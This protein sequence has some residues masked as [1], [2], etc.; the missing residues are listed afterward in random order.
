MYVVTG[1]YMF[2][3]VWFVEFVS[4]RDEIF[5]VL[6]ET[7][8]PMYLQ[9]QHTRLHCTDLTGYGNLHLKQP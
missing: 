5:T 7:Q 9:F 1:V 4:S 2:T 6:P 3:G 8:K